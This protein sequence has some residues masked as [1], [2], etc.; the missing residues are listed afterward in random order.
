MPNL[1]V[2]LE[3]KVRYSLVVEAE[4]REAAV[5]VAMEMFC[6][7]EKP[8]SDFEGERDEL[9]AFDVIDAWPWSEL[10]E[11]RLE[12]E[13]AAAEI[14][15]EAKLLRRALEYLE[16]FADQNDEPSG[17]DCRQLIA[18]IAKMVESTASSS[19]ASA[20][21][22]EMDSAEATARAYG[23]DHGGDGDGFWWDANEFGSWK[24]AVSWGETYESAA[25]VCEAHALD[26][27]AGKMFHGEERCRRLT[28]VDGDAVLKLSAR[29]LRAVADLR[30]TLFEAFSSHRETFIAAKG[31][32]F[33]LLVAIELRLALSDD[34]VAALSELKETW[35][36]EDA[37]IWLTAGPHTITPLE[38]WA[39]IPADR[40]L[41]AT[42]NELKLKLYERAEAN[43][44]VRAAQAAPSPAM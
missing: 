44:T 37:E 23:W 17:G 40:A 10:T 18:G 1:A 31:S 27:R 26:P 19:P 28:D 2:T 11:T 22:E 13:A 32:K 14:S 12:R 41:P 6:Q 36:A 3:E 24:E 43:A 42:F 5:A 8:F 15:E 38:V 35:P 25:E 30:P 4:D 20:A 9:R 34:D 33:G 7:S 39:F 16:R 29:E 21:G